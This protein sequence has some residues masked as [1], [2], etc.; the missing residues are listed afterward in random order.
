[1]KRLL[2]LGF[3]K[4][5]GELRMQHVSCS[6]LAFAL[7]LLFPFFWRKKKGFESN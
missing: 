6:G 4:S 3:V 2:A 5:M 1:M 7:L